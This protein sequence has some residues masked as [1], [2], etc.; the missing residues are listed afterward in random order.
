MFW[1]IL[2]VASNTRR[3]AFRNRAFVA[4]VFLGIAL[5]GTGW[6]LSLLA[7]PS[8]KARVLLDFGYF[9]VS[10][11][12]TLAFAWRR[13]SMTTLFVVLALAGQAPVILWLLAGGAAVYLALL[14]VDA[15]VKL[16]RGRA[17]G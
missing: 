4:L 8:Q 10:L 3:E 13:D 14:V 16:I 11:L 7:V 1:R 6:A 5:V 9:A 15:V 2:A 12:G 17:G